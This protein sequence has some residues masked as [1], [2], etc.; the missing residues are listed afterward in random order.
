MVYPKSA[1]RPGEP[2]TLIC[3]AQR[4]YPFPLGLAWARNGEPVA[5]TTP[6]TLSLVRRDASYSRYSLLPFTPQPGD[7]YTCHLQHRALR[8]PLVV[9]WEVRPEARPGAVL[10]VV[11]GGAMALGMLGVVTGSLLFCVSS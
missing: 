3:S 11:C 8:R 9:A 7:V 10:T 6:Q 2:N 1:V 4:Y 5:G